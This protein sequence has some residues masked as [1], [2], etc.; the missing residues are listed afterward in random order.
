MERHDGAADDLP[1]EKAN[2]CP[3]H[4][5]SENHRQRT[6]HDRR[7]LHIGSEPQSE[8][9]LRCTVSFTIGHH[10]NCSFLNAAGCPRHD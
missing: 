7:N 8:L 5:G 10:V 1:D 3:Y 4:I 9:A 6:I 2:D